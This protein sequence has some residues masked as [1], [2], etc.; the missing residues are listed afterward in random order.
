M[1][2]GLSCNSKCIFV[3]VSFQG[4][5]LDPGS[6][7]CQS[8]SVV[9]LEALAFTLENPVLVTDSLQVDEF[10]TFL[11]AD[12]DLKCRRAAVGLLSLVTKD[13]PQIPLSSV[14]LIADLLECQDATAS[15]RAA[16]ILLKFAGVNSQVRMQ[17]AEG[18]ILDALLK[19][20]PNDMNYRKKLT[21]T[22]ILFCQSGGHEYFQVNETTLSISSLHS[23][24]TIEVLA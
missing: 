23:K 15:Q 8:D 17:I 22:L 18:N 21:S 14:G 12:W 1:Y 5:L 13:N 2:G 4:L 10:L 6:K 24:L 11:G 20:Q 3:N 16:D 19:L 9:A 7:K